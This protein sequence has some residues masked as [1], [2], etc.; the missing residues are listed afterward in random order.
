MPLSWKNLALE[1]LSHASSDQ[2]EGTKSSSRVLKNTVY[3]STKHR[4]NGG[5]IEII[6]EFPFVLRHSK[7]ESLFSAPC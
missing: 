6:R 4:T 2:N 3:P 7:H 1:A 5:W